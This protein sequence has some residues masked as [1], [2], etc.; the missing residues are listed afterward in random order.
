[1]NHLADDIIF[2]LKAIRFQDQDIKILTQSENG[3]CPLIAIANVLIL[4]GRLVFHREVMGVYLKS[5]IDM[6][7]NI[8]LESDINNENERE[9][10]NASIRLLPSIA[11]GLDLNIIFNS[12]SS[13]EYTEELSLFDFLNIRL[14]HAW[15]VE[16]NDEFS[17][18]LRNMSYNSTV[19]KV[20]EYHSIREQTSSDSNLTKDQEEIL[21]YGEL[22]E[23]FLNTNIRQSNYTGLAGLYDTIQEDQLF[24]LF[25]NNHFST[26]FKFCNKLY[27]LVNDIGYQD[28]ASIIWE[29]LDNL[30]GDTRFFNHDFELSPILTDTN[31]SHLL[32]VLS[33]SSNQNFINDSKDYS[34]F[35]ADAP[36]TIVSIPDEYKIC[37]DD[38]KHNETLGFYD[39]LEVAKKLQEEEDMLFA[40]QQQE[41]E[42]GSVQ[43][44]T[45]AS[46]S[47]AMTPIE[48][49]R[50]NESANSNI[51]STTNPQHNKT[52]NS[53][54][55]D[56]CTIM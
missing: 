37:N 38:S 22:Y 54:K 18:I 33:D 12:N 55:K 26:V 2:Q 51:N 45:F 27:R 13:F 40:Q 16:G 29:L 30:D 31:N 6:I 47:A 35:E 5:L 23:T 56:K 19:L 15:L 41:L 32:S 50:V 43:V 1:M 48:L 25:E 8:L 7:G 52:K 24:I 3:P 39:D 36:E 20:V 44:G 9:I 14:Y 49:Q 4:Q 11:K 34:T 17:T 53:S 46:S 10:L 21:N 42:H 28:K